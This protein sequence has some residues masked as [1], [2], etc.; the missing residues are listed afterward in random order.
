MG[1]I[2]ASAAAGA[3]SAFHVVLL[4]AAILVGALGVLVLLVLPALRRLK[5]RRA[6]EVAQTLGADRALFIEPAANFFGQESLGRSQVRGQGCLAFTAHEVYFLMWLPKRAFRVPIRAIR[7]I[8]TPPSH[9]G[10]AK[11]RSLLKITF[12]GRRGGVDSMAWLVGDLAGARAALE[13]ICAAR[14]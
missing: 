8:D 4:V 1:A 13:R 14:Q 5:V 12:A 9:L 3:G 2:S 10:K 11:L 7:N 6:E